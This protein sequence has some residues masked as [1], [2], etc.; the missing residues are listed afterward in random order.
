MK[1]TAD[2]AALEARIE[3]LEGYSISLSVMV[4]TLITLLKQRGVL[5][6]LEAKTV[7]TAA[8]EIR[9]DPNAPKNL[10]ELVQWASKT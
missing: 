3:K 7:L 5:N 6:E 8:V 9:R 10:P 1:E 4:I 2:T